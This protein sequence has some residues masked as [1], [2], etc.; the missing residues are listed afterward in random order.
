MSVVAEKTEVI[1]TMFSAVI[2]H[3]DEIDTEDAVDEIV[4]SCRAKL[5]TTVPKAGL[6]FCG[7]EYD[8]VLLLERIDAAFPNMQLIGCTTDGEMSSELGFTEDAITLVL[9]TSDQAE[10]SAGI[11]FGA[12][13]A[14]AHAS[15]SSSAHEV[16][17][18]ISDALGDGIPIVGGMS[19]D[20]VGGTKSTYSTYQFCGKRVF[21]DSVPVM[22]F[23]GDLVYSLGIESGWKPI[24]EKMTVTRAE[25]QLLHELD[26]KPALDYYR[27]YLGEMNDENLTGLGAHPL[28]IF[29]D[30]SDRFYLRVGNSANA[31]TG[32]IHFL[33]N[34]P[35]GAQVQITQAIRDEVM[36]GVQRSV[37]DAMAHYPGNQPGAA[38][39]FSCTGRK[40]ALGSKTKDE[41]ARAQEELSFP[42]PMCGFYTFGELGPLTN[43]SE[44]RYHNTTFV[45][46]LIGTD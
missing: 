10:F 18:G 45:T 32:S 34:I 40:I 3:S 19:A 28:A 16:L 12:G 41:I 29:E 8:R 35:E 14:P 24:G 27:H 36:S 25:G 31:E 11:G 43:Q 30:N 42:V 23:G 44:A 22:L 5:G 7:T 39:L 13:T 26:G 33:G 15:L 9:F 1:L 17:A 2:G 21:T 38:L 37:S 4:A 20:R 6:L 46:L